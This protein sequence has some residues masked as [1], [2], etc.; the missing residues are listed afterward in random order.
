METS[1]TSASTS[2]SPNALCFGSD[3][4]AA[5]APCHID[6]SS[7]GLSIQF[8]DSG[9]EVIPFTA[10]SIEAGGFDHDQLVVKWARNGVGR[11]V[12]LKEPALIMAFRQF[13]PSDLLVHLERTAES[14]L[15]AR[16]GRR[17]FL[18]V[19]AA[20]VLALVLALWLGFDTLVRVAVAR[21]PVAWEQAIGE[22]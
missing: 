6:I 13:A 12:Y 7:G 16:Q 10:L 21:I 9:A 22:S 4:P 15:R 17:T 2:I 5:G 20:S 11:T 3:L 14:V 18:L 8:P 1:F 19:A